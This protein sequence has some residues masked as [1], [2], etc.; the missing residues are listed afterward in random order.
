MLTLEF[1]NDKIKRETNLNEEIDKV[2]KRIDVKVGFQCNNRCRFCVQGDKRYIYG[3]KSLDD[4]KRILEEG[5]KEFKNV[6]FTGGEP[7]IRKD[8]IAMVSYAKGLKYHKIQIQTNGRMFAS[9]SYCE[10][11]IS[12]GAN[13]FSPALHG[14]TSQLHDYLTRAE[15]SFKQTVAGIKNLKMLRQYV[16]TNTVIVK[17]NFRNLPQIAKLLAILKVDQFQFAFVHAVGEAGKNFNS[18]VPRK[19]LVEPYVKAGLNIGI[20][21]GIS[22]MTEAIP[23]CFMKGYENYVAEKI[24]PQTK[25]YDA[26]FILED[27]TKFRL[28]E[29][30]AKGDKCKSCKM[31]KICE[32][33]WKEYP[34]RFGWDEFKPISS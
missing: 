27:Y 6:V 26:D 4:V 9:K 19:K 10:D 14:H 34:E 7:T 13:E 31:E 16:I 20:K 32:G 18:I 17:P 21:A 3:N 15:G 11:I 29:G 5:R 22:V 1:N 33:P 25:I 28:V 23:Y 2:E 12:A 30:K 8:L 24:I